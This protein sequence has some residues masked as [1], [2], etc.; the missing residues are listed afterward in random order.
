MSEDLMDHLGSEEDSS[1]LWD[2]AGL[3]LQPDVKLS[4]RMRP[5]LGVLAPDYN[6]STH[7]RE[8]KAGGVA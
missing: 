1:T 6:P 4:K 7:T 3:G 2:V 5:K 8:T